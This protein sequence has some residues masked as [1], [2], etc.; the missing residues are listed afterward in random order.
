MSFSIMN[1]T[2]LEQNIR[3]GCQPPFH[4]RAHGCLLQ[5][6]FPPPDYTRAVSIL[7]R[8][9]NSTT[10]A[11]SSS[12]TQRHPVPAEVWDSLTDKRACHPLP[13]S[14]SAPFISMIVL[15]STPEETEKAIREGTFALIR[16]VM[17]FT[18]G[19]WVAITRWIP[20]ARANCARR[21]MAS[22]TSP[23]AYHH[24]IRQ[25]VDDDHDLRHLL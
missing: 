5:S 11:T 17:T 7:A 2:C 19:R 18:D 22:S 14:F 8:P 6:A 20:A 16:P 12:E 10:F 24:Q 4:F 13:S 1:F 15:E 9:E 3:P 25:L 21:Q 23:G